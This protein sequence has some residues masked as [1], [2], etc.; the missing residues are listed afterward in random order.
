[1]IPLDVAHL[2][3]PVTVFTPLFIALIIGEVAL[4][5]IRRHEGAYDTRDTF[6]SLAMGVG[7]VVSGLLL[8]GIGY[9][10]LL[11]VHQ[12][13]LFAIPSDLL[14][15]ALCFTLDDLRYYWSHRISHRSRWFWASHVVHHSSQHYNLSTALRQPWAGELS[16]LVVLQAP[17]ALL[18]FHPVMLAFAAA[19]NLVYQ[20]WI[21]TEAVDRLPRWFEAVFNTP[22]HHRAH[23]ARNPRYLDSNYAGTLIVW[24]RLFGTFVAE[25]AADPPRYGLVKNIGTH[26]PLRVATHEYA[27]ILQDV[28]RPGLSWRQ[29]LHYAFAEP[30]WS[31]DGSRRTSAQI[32]AAAGEV[33]RRAAQ[34]AEPA[35]R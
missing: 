1:M 24:D 5:A 29:R 14:T 2:P 35:R 17:L 30:G 13:A 25:D 28:R 27:G 22:S 10:V 3:S 33:G 8:K 12:R 21:H 9:A 16:G 7:N 32:K 20:F 4:L 19:L 18:G 26:N 11:W 23:H 6:T 15:L 34:G 31:H